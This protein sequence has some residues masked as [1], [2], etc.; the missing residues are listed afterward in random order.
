MLTL[1]TA[2]SLQRKSQRS[3]QVV[4][5]VATASQASAQSCWQVRAQS[6]PFTQAR[7][8]RSTQPA[9][10]TATLSQR[11][12]QSC[13]VGQSNS[14]RSPWAHTQRPAPSQGPPTGGPQPWA[15][16]RPRPRPSGRV[17]SQERM[18]EGRPLAGR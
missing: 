4:S 12:S 9:S 8:Q 13:W 17:S 7:S 6:L 2:V 10:H 3:P 15:S 16:S 5:Q 18:P 14:Q 11:T 1:Q